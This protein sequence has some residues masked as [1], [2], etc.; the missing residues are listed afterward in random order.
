M[1]KT[2]TSNELN[3]TFVFTKMCAAKLTHFTFQTGIFGKGFDDGV[4]EWDVKFR[5]QF[6]NIAVCST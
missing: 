6:S 5:K 4:G 3:E 2:N 1:W